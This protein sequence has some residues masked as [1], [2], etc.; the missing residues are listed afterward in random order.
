MLLTP[1]KKTSQYGPNFFDPPP[2]LIDGFKEY[3]VEKIIKHKGTPQGMKYLIRWKGYSPS[4]DTWE[5][6]DDLEYS[7][8]LLREYKDANKLPQDNAGT[9]FKLTKRKYH[10]QKS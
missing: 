5:W 6:E 7:G 9:H 10:T 4:D 8:E 2:D 1:Y 3:K